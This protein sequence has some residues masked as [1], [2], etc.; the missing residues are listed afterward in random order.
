M[1]VLIVED[2][3]LI[4]DAVRQAL[5][6]S[7]FAA[8]I[9]TSAEAA[10]S[11]LQAESFDLAVVDIGLPREDGLHLVRRLRAGGKATPILMLTA[12][13]GL[14]DRVNALDLGADDY[15]TKP[16]EVAELIAR[17]R[18]LIRRANSAANNQLSF[19]G[20]QLDMTHHALSIGS[21]PVE[22]TQREW[23][24]LECLVL[25]AGRIVS[26]D[27]LMSSVTDWTD[28]LTPNAIEVYVSR[29]RGKLG[30]AA[31]IRAVRGMGYRIDEKN[32]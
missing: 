27:K 7:G 12:R 19:G 14:S 29:L 8:D 2:D 22:L 23:S 5:T 11:A 17:C 10:A 24:I 15:M 31:R 3:P 13:D 1:R 6:R 28:D 16:F 25:N 20:L 26:K 21:K 32:K 4:A 9:V 18:A 30:D